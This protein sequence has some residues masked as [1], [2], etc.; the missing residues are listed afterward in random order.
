M[1][2]LARR[3]AEDVVPYNKKERGFLESGSYKRGMAGGDMPSLTPQHFVYGDTDKS[4]DCGEQ[5]NVG[6]AY[7]PFPF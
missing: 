7:L 5:E 2:I 3:T 1:P 4:G 6:V